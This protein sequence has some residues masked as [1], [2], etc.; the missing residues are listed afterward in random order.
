MASASTYEYNSRIVREAARKLRNCGRTLSGNASPRIGRL[1]S[2]LPRNLEGSAANALEARIAEMN[3]D[4][5]AMVNAMTSL[6]DTLDSY[7]AELER[8]ARELRRIM[9]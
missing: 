5:N 2:E 4:V 6:S 7:A 1:R 9:E 3:A 8:T